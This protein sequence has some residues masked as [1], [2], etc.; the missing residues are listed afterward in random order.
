MSTKRTGGVEGVNPRSPQDLPPTSGAI[1][2]PFRSAPLRQ[3]LAG[4]SSGATERADTID[5]FP[6]EERPLSP[7]VFS[8]PLP[9]EEIVANL[10]NSL[11]GGSVSIP[12]LTPLER[13][14]L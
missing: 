4:T 7:G 6:R 3:L 10:R 12:S 9:I 14:K 2:P 1:L 13:R 11:P 8:E 5:N